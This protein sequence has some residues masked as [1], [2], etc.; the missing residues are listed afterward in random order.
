[1]RRAERIRAGRLDRANQVNRTL[2]AGGN[3]GDGIGIGR[4]G[5]CNRD[6]I[7]GADVSLQGCARTLTAHE[8]NDVR[9]GR[10]HR[11]QSPTEMS[12]RTRDETPTHVNAYR[13]RTR[14]PERGI[15]TLQA[16]STQHAPAT[17]VLNLANVISAVRIAL[18]PLVAWAVVE[19]HAILTAAGFALVITSDLLDGFVARRRRQTTPFGTALDHSADALFVTVL[20]AIGAHLGLLPAVLAPLIALAFVQYAFDSRIRGQRT[21]RPSRLGR[22]NGIAYY[23]IVTTMSVAHVHFPDLPLLHSAVM[24][25]GWLLVAAT[26]VSIIER[27]WHLIHAVRES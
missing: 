17:A 13:R 25:M 5:E 22:I 20:A 16:M 27:A 18:T 26:A 3:P 11:D 6:A 7:E 12:V 4:V 8:R 1:M 9:S 2:A 14:G 24:S 10:E 19:G 15:V 23:I 21:L